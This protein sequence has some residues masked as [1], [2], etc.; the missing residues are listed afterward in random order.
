MTAIHE[1]AV[2]WHAVNRKNQVVFLGVV[3]FRGHPHAQSPPQKSKS[4]AAGEAL[5]STARTTLAA[6]DFRRGDDF[7]EHPVTDLL[8]YIPP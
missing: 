1:D 7:C 8:L 6:D 5:S 2:D 3:R 4:N